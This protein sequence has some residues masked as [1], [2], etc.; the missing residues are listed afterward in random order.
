MMVSTVF[1]SVLWPLIFPFSHCFVLTK[2]FRQNDLEFINLLEEVKKNQVS[3]KTKDMLSQMKRPLSLP[4]G[5]Y[6]PRLNP[7]VMESFIYNREKLH[8]TNDKLVIIDSIDSRTLSPYQLDQL[9]P[10]RHKLVLKK[11]CPV[12]CLRNFDNELKNGINGFVTSFIDNFPVIHFPKVNRVQYFSSSWKV[13]Y[14][15]N[16]DGKVGKRL[17]LPLTL[18]YSFTIHKSQGMALD[19]GELNVDRLF[20][21]GQGYTGLSRFKTRETVRLLNYDG[22]RPINIVS[23]SFH[24]IYY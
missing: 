24:F 23:I 19:N 3:E 5:E 8:M 6:V 16:K 14:V 21:P 11:G 13:L 15:V 10:V 1:L 20:S 12:M 2:I 17:Q 18:S 4:P 7:R 9:L 22:S